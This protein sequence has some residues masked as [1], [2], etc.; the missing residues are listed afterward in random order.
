MSIILYYHNEN[1]L[2]YTP[3]ENAIDLLYYQKAHLPTTDQFSEHIK[4][5]KLDGKT[6]KALESYIK[7]FGNKYE[8][9]IN[10]IK[11]ELSKIDYKIPLYDE[12]TKN[13]FIIPREVVYDRVIYGYF[14]FLD[15]YMINNFKKKIVEL[16]NSD[17]V[18]KKNL[19]KR[20]FIDNVIDDNN[21]DNSLIDTD[22]DFK[23]NIHYMKE[24][25]QREYEKLV[26][27]TDFLD[28]FD[29][30][31]LTT[32]Y[33][34]TFYYYSNHVGKNITVCVRPSFLPHFKHISP[35]YTKIEL[36]KLG[37]N[38][39]ILKSEDK[40]PDTIDFITELCNQIKKNDV[41]AEIIM[42][43]QNYIISHGKLGIVQY[44]SVQGSYFMN[45]YLRGNVKYTHRNDF[46]EKQIISMWELINSAPKFDKDYIVYRFIKSDE[47]LQHLRVGDEYIVP[48]FESTTRNPFY[49]KFDHFGFILIKVVLPA[50]KQGVALC[51]ET[52]SNFPEEQEIIMSPL[53]IFKLLKKDENVLYYHTD[54]NAQIK[55]KTKYELAYVGKKDIKF[56]FRP[57]LP[58]PEVYETLNFLKLH[59]VE[60][61]TLTEKIQYFVNNH[62]NE[63]YQCN[64]KIG[65]KEYTMLLEY[66]DSVDAYK[67][68]YAVSTNNGFLMY[69]IIENHIGFAIELSEQDGVS[70]MYVN[71][72]FRYSSVPANGKIKDIDLINFLVSIAYYFDIKKAII[73]CEHESCENLTNKNKERINIYLPQLLL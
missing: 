31:I 69:T 38:M 40:I 71:Y 25:K 5:K 60:L 23:Y 20:E 66:Y 46:L 44:Y 52:V 47:H 45:Q 11:K 63:M 50:N 42:R 32:T 41:S 54:T 12:Y 10:K 39:Q 8:K 17:Q 61:L 68:F 28:Q 18:V 55:V 58:K 36:I 62:A 67:N 27:M 19:K 34:K 6:M 1:T 37:L 51:M 16:E 59:K 9:I 65:D 3:R 22:I 70:T 57:E 48:S 26:L 21:N 30:E 15:K 7:K 2:K 33:I 43:H 29:I 49:S 13:L 72:Y 4:D 64:V 35:Y 53:T 56:K 73:Y 24:N 14:R